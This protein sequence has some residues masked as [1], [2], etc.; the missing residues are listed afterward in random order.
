METVSRV[1]GHNNHLRLKVHEV[2]IKKCKNCI[3]FIPVTENLTVG[4]K[5]QA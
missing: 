3:F 4:L 1:T 2:L 5:E